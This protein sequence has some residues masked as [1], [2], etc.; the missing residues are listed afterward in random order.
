MSPYRKMRDPVESQDVLPVISGWGDPP[1]AD[2]APWAVLEDVKATRDAMRVL[3]FS[4]DVGDGVGVRPGFDCCWARPRMW[5]QYG[6]N[7]RGACLLFDRDR[8]EAFL[9]NGVGD[10]RIYWDDCA[11]RPARDRG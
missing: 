6:D 10:E 2:S 1:G 8:L 3:A 9:Q 5:E 4:R 7:H 11:L